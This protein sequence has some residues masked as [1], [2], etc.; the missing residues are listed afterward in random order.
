MNT[1]TFAREN[2]YLPRTGFG[3]IDLMPTEANI[4]AV[5]LYDQLPNPIDRKL[6]S[7]RGAISAQAGQP[8]S[9]EFDFWTLASASYV[10]SYISTGID[11]YMN[12]VPKEGW[13]I[14]GKNRGAVDYIN[15]RLRLLRI[16]CGTTFNALLREI[17][18]NIIQ[19]SNAFVI[20]V[21]FKNKT[22][23]PGLKVIPVGKSKSTIGGLYVVHP[24]L[25][26]AELDDKGRI[27]AWLYTVGGEERKR[28]KPEEVIHITYKR[29]TNAL[30][31]QPFYLQVIEDVRTYRQLEWLT[32][33]LINRY[34]HPIIHVRK[35]R[36]PDGSYSNTG[37]D[38]ISATDALL[39]SMRPDGVMVTP[40]DVEID[41]HGIESQALRI[42][43]Y[44]SGWRKRIFAGLVSSDVAMGEASA[45]TRSTADAITAEMHD[46]ARAIQLVIAEA[47]NS[48][49]IFNF[50]LEGG[51]DPI[52]NPDEAHFE[53][54]DVALEENI[55]RRNQI[56][57]EWLNGLITE[58]EA[59]DELGRDPMDDSQRETTFPNLYG[60]IAVAAIGAQNAQQD[61]PA[62]PAKKAVD[63]KTRPAGRYGKK[64]S[65]G[66]KVVQK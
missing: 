41:V 8:I 59:R 5:V 1:P 65:P 2:A 26:K 61:D 64:S 21:P 29:P 54:N 34:L 11:K 7:S 33:A 19:F 44:L 43:G 31:G 6:S 56:L 35:G 9:A 50:L 39:K 13:R 55:K 66:G 16:T 63:N 32:V 49:I 47:I 15:Q 14:K 20:K 36:R 18:R 40:P 42:D 53:Y 17:E 58:E 62:A 60:A 28:F 23:I 12:L 52:T 3:T 51:F 25:M 46:M 10:D 45:G 48:D 24:G 27:K 4:S 22:P 37:D 30:Y 57:Q 38:G